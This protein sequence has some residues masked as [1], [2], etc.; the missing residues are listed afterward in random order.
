[1]QNTYINGTT[2]SHDEIVSF[3]SAEVM[4]VIETIQFLNENANRNASLA[5]LSRYIGEVEGIEGHMEAFISTIAAF[6]DDDDM[7]V[8]GDM[9]GEKIENWTFSRR[10]YAL[11]GFDFARNLIETA[12]ETDKPLGPIIDRR[13][14]A[15]SELYIGKYL[16]AIA[17]EALFEVVDGGKY[18]SQP[19]GFLKNV[20][21]DKEFLKFGVD[22][23]EP[24]NHYRAIANATLGISVEDI[25]YFLDYLGQYS[26]I[27]ESDVVLVGQRLTLTQLESALVD[28]AT[29]DQFNQR[30]V[31]SYSIAGLS[32][33]VDRMFP[34]NILAF[35]NEQASE[36]IKKLVSPKA[37]LR[38]IALAKQDKFGKNLF[39][40]DVSP[41]IFNGAKVRI[42]P[43]GLTNIA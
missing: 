4:N 41:E 21:V 34:K 23:T 13:M 32:Y 3:K 20:L 29:I 9:P 17:Y 1:M 11:K 42:M 35:W 38:G 5:F 14:R 37:D 10:G 2:F 22:E 24:R 40:W 30:L 25:H 7:F 15:I 31:P 26:D 28:N 16:P 36:I 27:N 33:V 8:E 43:E 19:K 39:T 12:Y 18:F 6:G